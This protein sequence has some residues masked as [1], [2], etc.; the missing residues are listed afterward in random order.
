MTEKHNITF[1]GKRTQITM[2][3]DAK[4]LLN[5][6][7]ISLQDLIDKPDPHKQPRSGESTSAWV[8]ANLLNTAAR[9]IKETRGDYE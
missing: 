9:V 7:N 5:A 6:L 4:Y 3:S 2:N 8:T 1:K